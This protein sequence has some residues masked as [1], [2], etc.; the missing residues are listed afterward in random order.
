[1]PLGI[2]L[3]IVPLVHTCSGMSYNP[4]QTSTHREQNPE[5]DQECKINRQEQR[6]RKLSHGKQDKVARIPKGYKHERQIIGQTQDRDR[7]DINYKGQV[8]RRTQIIGQKL[9]GAGEIITD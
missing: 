1:M 4:H 6:T 5:Q 9:D 2:I 8:K 7:R 3:K